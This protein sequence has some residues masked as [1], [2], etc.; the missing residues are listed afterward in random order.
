MNRKKL[1]KHKRMARQFTTSFTNT[2]WQLGS[3]KQEP[4]IAE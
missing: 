1:G 2:I 3:A 4:Y